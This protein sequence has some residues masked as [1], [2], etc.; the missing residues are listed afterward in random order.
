M[1]VD[2]ARWIELD[3]TNPGVPVSRASGHKSEPSNPLKN[4]GVSARWAG[5]CQAAGTLQLPS[6]FGRMRVDFARW[7]EL[8]ETNPVVL[9]SRASGYKSEPSNPLENPGVSARW[10][11][12]A[13]G[14][15]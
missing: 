7:V 15:G 10:G 5:A 3:E 1:R 14:P 4:P 6:P 8:D 9:V 11:H 12:L 13:G 2:F